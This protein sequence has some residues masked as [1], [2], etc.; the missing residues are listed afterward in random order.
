MVVDVSGRTVVVTG[1]SRGL[2]TSVA[3]LLASRG[4]K[5]VLVARS[6]EGLERVAASIRTGGGVAVVVP[7]DLG[8]ADAAT[9]LPAAL[10]QA[11]GP[12][13]ILVN[14]AGVESI[15]RFDHVDPAVISQVL[16]L[17][18]ELPMQ[19]ARALVP[20]MRERGRG[21]VVNVASLAGLAGGAHRELYCASK[22][23]LV[24]F[25]RA[26]R[27]SLRADGSPVSASAVCAGFVRGDGMFADTQRAHGLQPPRLLGTSTPEDVAQGVLRAITDDLPE[28][29]VNPGPMRPLLALG[30]LSPLLQEWLTP[31]FGADDLARAVVEHG[32]VKPR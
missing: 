12:V 30:A 21:H 7:F 23:G 32:G 1:A 16:W 3:T 10:Q 11:A 4:A 6:S 20:G 22:H 28:V 9:R 15:T 24:G 27:A 2:G 31:K 13:D 19:L 17:N 18:L 25:T 29:I 14:N 26:L 8:V 5:V